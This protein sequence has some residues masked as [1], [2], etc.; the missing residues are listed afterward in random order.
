[1]VND[2]DWPKS[3][4]ASDYETLDVKGVFESSV[5][6]KPMVTHL[7]D[8]MMGLYKHYENGVLWRSGGISDQPA[9]YLQ[10]MEIIGPRLLK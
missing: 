9:I 1:M 6:L 5:C 3:K 10:A 2:P 8:Q 4:G 7:S